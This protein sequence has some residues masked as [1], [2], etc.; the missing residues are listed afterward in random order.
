MGYKGN[1]MS[2]GGDALINGFYFV[3][4]VKPVLPRQWNS[5]FTFEGANSVSWDTNMH[6]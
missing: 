5:E 1:P 6:A 3:V 4:Y 2:L